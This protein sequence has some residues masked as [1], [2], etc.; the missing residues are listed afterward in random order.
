MRWRGRYPGLEHIVLH[1]AEGMPRD[2][3]MGQLK[4]FAS[5]VMP[6]FRR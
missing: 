6:A 4:T 1:W 2:E 3:F 5:E